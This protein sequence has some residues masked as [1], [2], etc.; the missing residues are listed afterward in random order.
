MEKCRSIMS[1]ILSVEQEVKESKL[2]IN[3][4]ESFK[5]WVETKNFSSEDKINCLDGFKTL[6][7]CFENYEEELMNYHE[8]A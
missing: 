2:F 5:S 8:D 6:V 4:T 1:E 7:T 3:L